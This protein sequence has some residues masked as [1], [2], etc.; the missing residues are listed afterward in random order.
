MVKKY[1]LYQKL[2]MNY[3]WV[4]K[5]FGSSYDFFLNDD[6]L[7]SSVI[8]HFSVGNFLLK[9]SIYFKKVIH[10]KKFRVMMN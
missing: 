10:C 4:S 5:K 6:V 9:D 7:I 8:S 2:G 1:Q 3:F